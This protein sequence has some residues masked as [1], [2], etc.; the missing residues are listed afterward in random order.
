M[1]KKAASKREPVKASD[2]RSEG[3]I[4]VGAITQ[5]VLFV[6]THARIVITRAESL[7]ANHIDSYI[8]D[9]TKE[10]QSHGWKIREIA[11]MFGVD[12]GTLGNA[13]RRSA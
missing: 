3:V 2:L 7:A 9:R 4:E 5:H 13:L 8:I 12:S 11:P 10:L 1:R 6:R